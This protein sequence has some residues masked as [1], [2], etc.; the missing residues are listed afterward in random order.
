[1]TEASKSQSV[2]PA[3]VLFAHSSARSGRNGMV[4]S[5]GARFSEV[6]AESKT[7]AVQPGSGRAAAEQMFETKTQN[8]REGRK[9][10]LRSDYREA[11]DRRSTARSE[12]RTGVKA[13]RSFASQKAPTPEIAMPQSANDVARRTAAN[14]P[15]ESSN[16]NASLENA[17]AEQASPGPAHADSIREFFVP[18]ENGEKRATTG[19]QEKRIPLASGDNIQ[20]RPVGAPVPPGTSNPQAAKELARLLAIPQGTERGAAPVQGVAGPG[21]AIDAKPEVGVTKNAKRANETRTLVTQPKSMRSSAATEFER[22]IR[23]VRASSG[24]QSST[25]LLLDP[26]ELGKVHVRV[27]VDGDR[28]EVGVETE[29]ESAR[30]LISDRALKLKTALEQHGLVIDRFEVTTNQGGLFEPLFAAGHE[31]LG[32]RDN[33]NGQGG[34]R[35]FTTR[36]RGTAGDAQA[37]DGPQRPKARAHDDMRVDIQI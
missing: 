14:A 36:S 28:V 31:T 25:R 34:G 7:P 26:P 17:S 19:D 8:T 35:A 27:T 29:N 15:H 10:N 2:V 16:R 24:R 11:V 33:Q 32:P 6:L 1:M 13:R 21:P 23:L 9:A 22:L 5:P 37:I 18:E 12:S 20:M 3:A 30:Q 4:E